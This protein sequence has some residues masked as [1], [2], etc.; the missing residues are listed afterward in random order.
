MTPEEFTWFTDPEN[1]VGRL[2][3]IHMLILDVIMS[4]RVVEEQ[5]PGTILNCCKSTAVLWIEKVVKELPK[6]YVKYAEW[7]LSFGRSLD[8]SI[9][10]EDAI[11]K[12][13]LLED[14][15]TDLG[16]MSIVEIGI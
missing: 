16:R 5:G 13:L 6:E 10:M 4:R 15:S 12:P 8:F 1:S 2:L 9:N 7:P 11:W 14:R 3:I